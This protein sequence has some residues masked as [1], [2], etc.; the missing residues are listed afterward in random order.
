MQ[1]NQ[2]WLVEY[3]YVEFV[4]NKSLDF[5]LPA[6]NIP[7]EGLKSLPLGFSNV[8]GGF[9]ILLRMGFK[10]LVW[11]VDCLDENYPNSLELIFN[12]KKEILFSEK[13]VIFHEFLQTFD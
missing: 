6:I 11:Q 1:Q 8:K 12:P 9:D 7:N 4:H 3:P 13:T 10:R 2:N 5:L